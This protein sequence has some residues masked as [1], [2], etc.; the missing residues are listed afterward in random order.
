VPKS[1]EVELS[2]EISK[3]ADGKA[4]GGVWSIVSLE[5]SAKVGSENTHRVK[6]TLEPVDSSGKP[7]LISSSHIQKD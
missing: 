7:A 6:L 2:I 4:S 1:V 3:E 5:G